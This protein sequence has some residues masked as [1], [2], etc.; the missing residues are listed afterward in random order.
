MAETTLHEEG[1]DGELVPYQPE[2]TV[3]QLFLGALYQ[4][5]IQ[6]VADIT[7]GAPLVLVHGGDLC[8]GDAHPEQLMSTRLSDQVF[9]AAD[10]LRRWRNVPNLRAVRIA[11]GTA[12]HNSG[13]GSLEHLVAAQVASDLPDVQ[14]STHWRLDIGGAVFDVA[15]HGPS[16]GTRYWT[17]GNALLWYLRDLVLRDVMEMGERP[18]DAVLRFHYHTYSRATWHYVLQQEN[19]TARA[20][21]HPAYCGMNYYG[22]KA[23]RSRATTHYG[24]LLFRVVDGEIVEV[25]DRMVVR[26]DRQTRERVL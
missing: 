23:T 18:P 20:F 22:Q 16:P 1:P 6:A 21:I 11:L 4:D 17:D 2:L 24:M 14:V 15:H 8:H 10:M 25:V 5:Q 9:I 19:C 26:V 3:T 7:A 13:E 12:A